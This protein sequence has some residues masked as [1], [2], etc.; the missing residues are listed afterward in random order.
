MSISSGIPFTIISGSGSITTRGDGDLLKKL[1]S[2]STRSL[3]CLPIAAS[4]IILKK[5][6]DYLIHSDNELQRFKFYFFV[7]STSDEN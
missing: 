5:Q 6:L 2:S 1:C 3:D 7:V 4:E